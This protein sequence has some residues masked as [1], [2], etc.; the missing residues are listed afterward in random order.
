M[1]K[2][3]LKLSWSPEAEADLLEIWHWGA[4]HFS[5]DIADKHLRDI[6]ASALNLSDFPEIGQKRDD[7]ARMLRSIVIYPTVLFYRIT[8]H[9]VEVV[10]VIDGRQ[11]LAAIFRE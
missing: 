8:G 5:I 1:P 6:H 11:N 9:S 3:K 4:G 7:L 2:A 10:R